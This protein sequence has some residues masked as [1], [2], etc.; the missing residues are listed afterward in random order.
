MQPIEQA[1]PA[2]DQV[3]GTDRCRLATE[4]EHTQIRAELEEPRRHLSCSPVVI[5]GWLSERPRF[6]PSQKPGHRIPNHE[7]GAINA[8]RF[9][10]KPSVSR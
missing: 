8:S 10:R 5:L 2:S 3:G 7:I 9:N 6:I 1:W 4:N